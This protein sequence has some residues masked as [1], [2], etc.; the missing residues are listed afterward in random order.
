[1][2]E[3]AKIYLPSSEM[4]RQWYN[5]AADLPTPMLPPLGPDGKPVTFEQMSAIFPGNILEQEM[6]SKQ[7]IDIPEEVR[8][9]L[10]RWRP[11][12]LRRAYWLEQALGTPAKIYYKMKAQ[13]RQGVIKGT[14]L[15][16][17]LTTI[18]WQEP[19]LLPLKPVQVSGAQHFLLLVR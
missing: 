12:P 14:L 18:K 17:R 11:T 2:Y 13:V 9:H 10:M 15:L 4:P 16:R 5:L 19:K 1:M 8:D 6:S 3:D 7:W